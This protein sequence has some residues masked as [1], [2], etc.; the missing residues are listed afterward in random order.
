MALEKSMLSCVGAGRC[1]HR[2][3]DVS[4]YSNCENVV[5]DLRKSIDKVG[6]LRGRT[7]PMSVAPTLLWPTNSPGIGATSDILDRIDEVSE[8]VRLLKTEILNLQRV[9]DQARIHLQSVESDYTRLKRVFAHVKR[10]IETGA[11]VSPPKLPTAPVPAPDPEV[12]MPSS[13][14]EPSQMNLV[15]LQWHIASHNPAF[16][17]D[18]VS[19]RFSL[20]THA[21][22]CTVQFDP[23]G[24]CVAFSD[25]RLL[26]VVSALNGAL[27]YS[28]EIPKSIDRNELHTRVLRFSHDGSLIALSSMASAISVFSTVTKQCIGSL[29]CHK[30]AVAS[31]LF[32][33][34]SKILVSG[35]YDGLMCI[36]DVEK[37]SLIRRIQ[38]GVDPSDGK[39]Y[40]EGAIVAISPDKEETVVAVGFMNGYVGIYEP[41]FT[42]PM[43]TFSAHK[44]YLLSVETVPDEGAVVTTSNDKTAKLWQLRGIATCKHTFIGH[45]DYVLTA[46][47]MNGS[48]IMITGSKDE[49]IKGWNR[50]TGE[51][52]FTINGH[53]DTLFELH[54]HPSQ[55]SFVSCS[56]DGLVCVWDYR[57]PRIEK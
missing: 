24:E 5:R 51:L 6:L 47:M 4:F 10:Q 13:A 12:P 25:G 8:A 16:H 53:R 37:M 43:N 35:S 11:T 40:K 44:E 49:T 7:C 36:W 28:I 42:Q 29:E 2:S 38:H 3:K 45:A 55:N 54:H 17:P 56:V 39:L 21:V 14:A 23:T 34:N 15:N 52:L 30:K 32:M 26:H 19:L 33:K 46:T 57:L 27:M 1:G 22:L 9:R 20:S 50:K 18:D 41:T 31:L 48:P